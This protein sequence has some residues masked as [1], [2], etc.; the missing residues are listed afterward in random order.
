MNKLTKIMAM[1]VTVLLLTAITVSGQKVY[2]CD[3]VPGD[4]LKIRIY[5][6][7]NGLK[8]YMS[9]YKDAPRIQ[10]AI[11][12]KTGSKN[13]PH[14]NTG[15]SHYLEHMMFKGTEEFGTKD[16]S[17]EKPLLDQIENEFEI[18]RKTTDSL[19]RKQIYHVIDSISGVASKFAIAN[20]YDKLLS[21]IGAKG[22][23]AFTSF[24]ETVYVND[25]PSN[26]IKPWLDIEFDRFKD[27]VFRLFHTELETVYEEKNIGLD[28]DDEKVFEAMFS[29]LFQKHT[30]GTQT[31]I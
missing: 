16:Y 24:E 13:D 15:L 26:K 7:S 8:V 3:T 29:G 14:D 23:N 5:T 17:Q 27:P 19:Q 4:P 9:V 30:Y 18:Y 12:V 31:T 25:I 6:L 20:E 21:T 22:T 1:F 10:T 2:K 28:N 11:A